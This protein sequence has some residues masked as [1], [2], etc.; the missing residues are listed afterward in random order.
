MK[1][2]IARPC[3]KEKEFCEKNGNGK[4]TWG[5]V[6][7]K[8]NYMCSI[9]GEYLTKEELKQELDKQKIEELNN[10]KEHKAML[11]AMNKIANEILNE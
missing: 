4:C 2:T 11:K 7:P 10:S 6:Y 5:W 8:K 9:C 3:T 1:Q